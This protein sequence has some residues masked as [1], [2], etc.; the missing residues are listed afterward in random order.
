MSRGR[1][2]ITD[3]TPRPGTLPFVWEPLENKP[4]SDCQ[5]AVSCEDLA[6]ASSSLLPALSPPP[7]C[8]PL[9]GPASLGISGWI[10]S[11]LHP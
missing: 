10:R 11:D 5:I 7:P 8:S 3:A 6:A 4:W 2:L 9:L 1:L